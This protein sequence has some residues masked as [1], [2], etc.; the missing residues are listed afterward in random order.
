MTSFKIKLSLVALC[1]FI[2][3]VFSTKFKIRNRI[4]N[5]RDSENGNFP[6][7]VFLSEHPTTNFISGGVI[8]SEWH[9]LTAAHCVWKYMDAGENVVVSYGVTSLLDETI[10]YHVEK[11]T[12]H[13]NFDDSN[14]FRDDI[15]I[16]TM[17]DQI[18]FS[19]FVQPI[20]IIKSK[21]ADDGG[22]KARVCGFGNFNPVSN[23]SE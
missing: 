11:F 15:A 6:Y 1:F 21:L 23:H 20:P 4:I 17:N 12:I 16:L 19:H 2:N 13:P 10:G 18:E 22:L 8:I 5:G 9:V 14:I 7:Y 3:A